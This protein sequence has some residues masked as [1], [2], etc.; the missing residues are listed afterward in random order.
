MNA[1]AASPARRSSFFLAMAILALCIVLVGFSGT[2]IIPLAKGTSFQPVY[3][4]HGVV[5][6]G[7]ILLSIAQ[8]MLVKAGRI[9]LHRNVG[10]FGGFYALLV[11]IMGLYVATEAAYRDIGLGREGGAKTFYLIP[12]T[13]MILFAVFVGV[14][15]VN[16]RNPGSHKRLMLLANHALL[17]AAFGRLAFM[18][19][20]NNPLLSVLL[21]ELY[22]I[23]ALAFDLITLKRI[24]PVYR[25]AA[26]LAVVVHIGRLYLATTPVWH[27]ITDK[28]LGG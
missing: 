5:F 28:L 19:G 7:W 24:H 1:I 10:T 9:S 21:M 22:L 26:T 6:F 3:H 20:I 4:W 12:I 2:Y 23:A 8:P 27:D 17:P 14:G 16:R 25:W 13:D 18:L 11:V 15:I